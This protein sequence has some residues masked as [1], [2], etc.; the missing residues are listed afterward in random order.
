MNVQ[1]RLQ[2][3]EEVLLWVHSRL[4]GLKIRDLPHVKRLQL[5]MAC[6]HVAVE[7]A[8]AIVVLLRNG[9][10]GSALA[11][12]RPLFEAYVRGMW[13]AYAATDG[14]VDDAGRDKFPPKF[15]TLTDDLEQPGKLPPGLL[16]DIR[17]SWWKRMCSLTHSGYQQIGARLTPDGLGNNYED[18]EVIEALT[19]AD[20][21]TLMAAIEFAGAANDEPLAGA[22]LDRLRSM[23]LGPP[24]RVES[25]G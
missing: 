19:W 5:A 3:S 2:Q 8:Q 11:L 21:I 7:H 23:D 14:Q 12:K 6:C 15:K 1:A 4:E 24:T 18:S 10:L 22:A 25:P 20:M 16:S 13:L 9:L 17:A